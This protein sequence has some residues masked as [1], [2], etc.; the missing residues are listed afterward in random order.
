MNAPLPR[1]RY[2]P[3]VVALAAAACVLVIAGYFYLPRLVSARLPAD[4]IERLGFAGFTGRVSR[5]GLYRTMAGPLVFGHA[6]DPALAIGSVELDYTPGELRRRKIRYLRMRDVV[7]NARVGAEGIAFPGFDPKA[8]TGKGKPGPPAIGPSSGL[9]AFT[10]QNIEIRGGLVHLRHGASTTRIPFDAD[11]TFTGPGIV[12]MDAHVKLLL[13]DQALSLTARVD[14]HGREGNL[15]LDAP[16]VILDRFA[17]WIRLIPGLE[18]SGTAGFNVHARMHWRPFGL[19]AVHAKLTWP[20]GWLTYGAIHLHAGEEGEPVVLRADSKAMHTWRISARGV[21]VDTPVPMVVDLPAATVNLA[22]DRQTL[23]GQIAL[24]MHP[25]SLAHPQPVSLKAPLAL[26]L[27]FQADRTAKGHWTVAVESEDHRP[28]GPSPALNLTVAAANIHAAAPHLR[29]MVRDARQGAEANWSLSLGA[30][31]AAAAGTAA[32]LPSAKADGSLRFFHSP[33]GIGWSGD[34]RLRFPGLTLAHHKI[35]GRF[36]AVNVA[37]RFRRK[38]G[39]AA[40]VNGRLRLSG[41]RLTD[42]ASGLRLSGGRA[43]LPFGWDPLSGKSDGSYSIARVARGQLP[44]GRIHGRLTR[45]ASGYAVSGTGVGSFLPGMIAHLSGN[46]VAIGL[47]PSG[48]SFTVDVPAFQLPADDDLGRLVPAAHGVTLTGRLSARAKVSIGPTGVGGSLNLGLAKGALA[49]P[50][51]HITL[52][53]IDTRMDFPELPRIRSAPAQRIRFSRAA[54]GAIVVD[55]GSVDIQVE[56]RNTLFVEKGRLSWCG[57]KVDVQSL[58]V[59]AG[60]RDYNVGLY[61]QRLSL[62]RILEQ[63]GAVHAK[64]SGTLNGRIPVVYRNGK[65]RFDDG[66]LFS[67]PGEGGRIQL[68]G[69]DMLTRGIPAGTPQFAQVDLAREALKDYKYKWARLGL[70]SEGQDVVLRLQ[71]DGKPAN[72]LP[73][74]YKK[75][76]GRFVRIEADMEGSRFQGISLDVNLRLPLNR[77]LQYKGIVKMIE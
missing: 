7:I 56:S 53:G 12:G 70:R 8:L 39:A 1:R 35:T 32:D 36:D 48:A 74:V 4:R 22:A 23:S 41:G 5:I 43:D 15:S 66:F 58:R 63:L 49:M 71:F 27:T 61:C 38:A 50:A 60:R 55:G 9:A 25:F 44:L 20:A 26:P 45:T 54:M 33:H 16:A 59:T 57:G 13:R 18:A 37:A 6:D 10:L 69:T 51:R 21:R 14:G 40:I 34:A 62:S 64:G 73:F 31:H 2:W 52:E 30:L 3:I 24:K 28:P 19:T 65:V 67:T 17:D 72:P 75:S 42:R 68:T 47:R 11:L 46:V 77:L 76:L 29:L